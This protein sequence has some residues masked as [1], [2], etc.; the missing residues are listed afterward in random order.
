MRTLSFEEQVKQKLG[1]L[2]KPP[3]PPSD[4][5]PIDHTAD[6]NLMAYAGDIVNVS[7]ESLHPYPN[8]PFKPYSEEKMAALVES[9]EQDGLYQ[10][11]IIRPIAGIAG[12]E[13]LAGHNRVEAMRRLGRKDVSAIMRDVDDDKAALVVVSTNLEQRENLLPSEKAFAYEMQMEAL[14][15]IGYQNDTRRKGEVI[16]K[17][18]DDSY[19][20]IFRYIRLTNLCA[21]YLALIDQNKLPV[22]AGYELSFLDD[23][24]QYEVWVYFYQENSN[25]R[26]T[27]KNAKAIRAAY[28]AGTVITADMIPSILSNPKKKA[29]G[30]SISGK[31]LRRYA[32]PDG[33]DLTA[34]FCE[35]L[36]ERF[37]RR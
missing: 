10:P 7:I 12:F 4:R 28:E 1:R 36:E 29:K 19:A 25:E 31:M 35:L 6:L 20:Q 33:V 3:E 27:V 18:S 14:R 17:T 23:N 24:A 37:G 9:I 11:I 8:H 21:E 15:N 16:S 30:V 22:M 2:P 32:I 13:I 26:L 34:L 5:K